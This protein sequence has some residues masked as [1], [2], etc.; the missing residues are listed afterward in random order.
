[1]NA[2]AG[3]GMAVLTCDLELA[4]M[5]LVR[6]VDGLLKIGRIL[7]QSVGYLALELRNQFI[8]LKWE[9]FVLGGVHSARARWNPVSDVKGER[10]FLSYLSSV[11]AA[12]EEATEWAMTGSSDGIKGPNRI[13]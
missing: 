5:K 7:D 9:E 13:E 8:R 2:P 4:S 10:I 6:I 3:T 11:R 12:D 1:M